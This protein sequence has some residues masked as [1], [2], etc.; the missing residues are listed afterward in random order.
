MIKVLLLIATCSAFAL[1][2]Q[3]QPHPANVFDIKQPGQV[4]FSKSEPAYLD[5]LKTPSGFELKMDSAPGLADLGKASGPVPMVL[6]LNKFASEKSKG[7]QWKNFA[8]AWNERN[9]SGR[10]KMYNEKNMS[11]ETAY[12]DSK[13][14]TR[15]V[16]LLFGTLIDKP[17]STVIKTLNID[18]ANPSK[19]PESMDI[20]HYHF[21]ISGEEA[22]SI[23]EEGH[24]ALKV[25]DPKRTYLLSAFNVGEYECSALSDNIARRESEKPDQYKLK[26]RS[27]YV[28]SDVQLDNPSDVRVAQNLFKRK[29][30]LL[31]TQKMIYSSHLLKNSVTY[32]ALFAEGQKTR[33]VFTTDLALN[34]LYWDKYNGAGSVVLIYGF[35]TWTGAAAKGYTI[36]VNAKD[37]VVDTASKAK[38]AVVDTANAII[39]LLPGSRKDQSTSDVQTPAK[40][41]DAADKDIAQKNT[42]NRGLSQGLIRYTSQ[43]F[44]EYL[45]QINK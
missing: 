14:H 13:K 38:D 41:A 30:D 8:K 34:S 42:C 29:P 4:Y 33:V 44:G 36:A 11:P 9:K 7:R 2:Y 37:A 17:I 32:F 22:L 6:D 39:R 15:V 27:I 28:V 1:E 16:E 35:G 45:N 5:W 40:S 24:S 12:A 10:P 43:L 21:N 3:E 31:L 18:P 25:I 26:N 23:P 20:D 19:I